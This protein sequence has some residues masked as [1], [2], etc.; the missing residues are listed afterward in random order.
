MHLTVEATAL[1]EALRL[2]VSPN[3]ATMPVLEHALLETVGDALRV[4]TTDL[5][6]RVQALLP[7]KVA[8]GGAGGVCADVKTL[9][10][11]MGGGGSV[12]L[13]LQGSPQDSITVRRGA[14]SRL[15]VPALPA[16]QWPECDRIVWSGSGIDPQNLAAAIDAVAYAAARNDVRPWANCVALV[17]GHAY[18]TDG[19]RV[20]A[21]PVNCSGAPLLIPTAA[22]PHLRKALVEGAKVS[23]GVITPSRVTVLA[24]E[25]AAA[26]VQTQLVDATPPSY[27]AI[28]PSGDPEAFAVVARDELLSA[29]DRLAPFCAR[30]IG[31]NFIHGCMVHITPDGVRLEDFG[32][33]NVEHIAVHSANGTTRG[34]VGVAYLSEA[35]AAIDADEITIAHHS[36]G[37][38]IDRTAV[39]A[40][41]IPNRH[42]IA[43]LRA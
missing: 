35:I 5:M 9:R 23:L 30:R 38:E 33:E 27:E 12:E 28:F 29:L 42:V 26:L 37:A 32:G 15:R 14:R 39:S 21:A 17:G 36:T 25:S 11:A 34:G 1:A 16:D 43:G 3:R 13:L 20:A 40:A 31:K 22:L 6:L 24:V 2:G 8:E 18:A 19:H 10:A 41:G 7:A 4:T